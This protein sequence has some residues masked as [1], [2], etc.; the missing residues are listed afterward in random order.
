MCQLHNM[1]CVDTKLTDGSGFS[2]DF[3]DALSDWAKLHELKI[4]GNRA[5]GAR[6]CFYDEHELW[7]KLHCGIEIKLENYKFEMIP[8]SKDRYK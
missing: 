6:F 1:I 3:A 7:V 8:D 2:E 4:K 5:D